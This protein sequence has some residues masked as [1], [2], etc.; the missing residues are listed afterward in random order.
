L[1]FPSSLWRSSLKFKSATEKRTIEN[2]RKLFAVTV[3]FPFL[4]PVVRMLV[5]LPAGGIYRIINILWEGYTAYFRLYKT[6]NR[7]FFAG[8]RKYIRIFLQ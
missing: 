1:Y 7:G 8:I 2:L 3:E 6:G 4:L 5:Y